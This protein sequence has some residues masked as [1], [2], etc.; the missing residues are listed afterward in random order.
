MKTLE[1]LVTVYI[2]I[3]AD[4]YN[5]FNNLYIQIK[6]LK[7]QSNFNDYYLGFFLFFIK[8]IKGGRLNEKENK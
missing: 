3:L 2:Y 1:S 6:K 7:Q 4:F 8:Q 5:L